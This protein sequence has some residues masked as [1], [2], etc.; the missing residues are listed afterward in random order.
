MAKK[1]KKYPVGTKIRFL[2]KYED[3]GKEGVII[4]LNYSGNPVIFIPTAKKHIKNDYYPTWN[5]TGKVYSWAC[6]WHHIERIAQVGEQLLFDFM[7]E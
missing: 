7:K 3:T 2:Y 4:A 6:G 5:D 1:V